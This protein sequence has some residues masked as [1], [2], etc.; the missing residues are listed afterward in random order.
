[1]IV[2]TINRTIFSTLLV[3]YAAEYLFRIVPQNT[4]DEN[5]F[6]QPD[7]L[8]D[9]LRESKSNLRICLFTKRIREL[10]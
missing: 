9:M 1:M 6:I 4:H 7:E 2:T 5:K 8:T 10:V 3:K